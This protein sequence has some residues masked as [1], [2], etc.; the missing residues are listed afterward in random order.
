L[1]DNGGGNC[2]FGFSAANGTVVQSDATVGTKDGSRRLQIA[3]CRRV[4]RLY[5]GSV[6]DD[7]GAVYARIDIPIAMIARGAQR[8]GKF[9][10]YNIRFNLN[11]APGLDFGSSEPLRRGYVGITKRSPFEGYKEHEAK[12]RANKGHL[13]HSAWYAV[14]RAHPQVY[15]VFQICGHADTLDDAYAAEEKLVA[16]GTLAPRGLNVIP[17]GLAGIRELHRLGALAKHAAP[18]ADERDRAVEHLERN[19]MAAH[20]RRAHMRRLANERTVFVNGCW[21]AVKPVSEAA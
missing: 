8:L 10:I 11:S 14:A 12:A 5:E 7:N 3:F 16:E 18:S 9:T 2:L 4:S 15:P 17:G 13:L 1:T 6:V 19:A 20:Y 21:V